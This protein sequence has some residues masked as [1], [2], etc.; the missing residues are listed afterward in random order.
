[1]PAKLDV[2]YGGS[3]PQA[4]F[5]EYHDRYHAAFVDQVRQVTATLGQQLVDY[6]EKIT[7][8][9]T[10]MD[11]GSA[12][13]DA[14]NTPMQIE[15]ASWL[16]NRS[17]SYLIR[18]AGADRHFGTDD[19][20][21][22]YIEDRTGAVLNSPDEK[23]ILDL[24][25]EHARGPMNGLTE[26][27]GVITDQSGAVIPQ[28]TITVRQPL[29]ATTRT[30][31][32]GADGS[33]D[34]A[35]LPAGSYHIEV[36]AP[37][38]VRL[39][40][41][42]RLLP[43]D[44]VM[45]SITLS[46]EAVTQT[47]TVE[48]ADGFVASPPMAAAIGGPVTLPVK[49]SASFA[50]T[51]NLQFEA[52][53]DKA[54]RKDTPASRS[55]DTAH[56]RSY[57]PEA[58]YINPEIITDGDGRASVSIPIADSITTWRMA[59]FASTQSGAIGSGT[60][61]LKVLQD[62]FVDIDLPVTLTQGDNISIP[63]A[64]YDYTGTSG[65]VSLQLKQEDWFSL[66]HDELEK[67]V[68][69][70]AGKVGS[71]Q[72]NI[73]A[74]RI[75]R[76]KLTL[77]AQL[78]GSGERKDVVV[79]EVQVIPNGREQ[80]L[81]FNGRL[82][83]SVQHKVSFPSNA[84]PDATSIFVRLYP[85]PLSQIIEG[86][87]SILSMPGGCFEQTSSNTYPNVLALEYMKRTN[88]L[89]PETH[90]K[91][92]GYIANGYQRLLTF[93]VPGGGF[94]WFGQA[95]ANKILTAYGL[96]EF[97]DMS[98]VSDVDPR[99]IK[100]TAEW[101]IS[102]QQPD[103]SWKPDTYFIN[104]GATNRYNSDPLRI[105]AYVAWALV[106]S[107][108]RGEALEKAKGYIDQH[109]GS[110]QDPYT[111]AIVANFAVDYANDRELTRGAMRALIDAGTEKDDQIWWTTP[112]TGVYSE[113]ESAAVETTGLA[114]QALLKW[115]QASE[116]ARKALNFISAK[117]Q[118]SGNWGTTQATV[119]ALRALVLAT[120]LNASNIRGSLVVSL[121]GKTV[122][123]LNLTA[124]NN[125]PLHQ[126]VLKG[127]DPSAANEVSLKFDGSGSLAYQ[128]VGRS[129]I[130]WDK[131]PDSEALSIDVAYDRTELSRGDIVTATATIH[132]NL[133]KLAKMVM[134]DLGIPPGFD[135]LSEDLQSLQEK[136][137]GDQG[138]RLE[139]FSLTA[140]QAILYFNALSPEQTVKIR[141]RLRAKYPIRARTFASRVYEYY[142][143]AV[144]STA[145]P[146]ELRVVDERVQR[147][148]RD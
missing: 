104:E 62:F 33:F 82:E 69:V 17:Q 50:A 43:R 114:T 88:K 27:T 87:D 1:M 20:L 57:F 90:A 133:P 101:L 146:A 126:F 67:S 2:Q 107:G 9:F 73:D 130:P 7:D 5:A 4:K 49:S 35:G 118:S 136:T 145:K 97:S 81:T 84:I 66:E 134:V 115:G 95:P 105:T 39:S 24:R 23:G 29:L 78:K 34:L 96:M 36:S 123:T 26:I 110:S 40:D 91:A 42:I 148:R 61:S 102:Q 32:S 116:T 144:S 120:Q 22:T 76:F 80:N 138:G 86:M 16:G 13:R 119:M 128:I 31:H 141:F 72:F 83:K 139:K 147:D 12:P 71:S 6:R 140:T 68:H 56:I 14:W 54:L 125:D 93:E 30:A 60:S 111:L 44:R 51:D 142:D 137:Q 58:L 64:I 113:G 38:F 108:Y 10:T 121:D 47:V 70:E 103:G 53:S 129:F 99:L 45:A 124:D 135:L 25:F 52:R 11:G 131:Q 55:A 59:M 94:S 132:N 63:V 15:L 127:I 18:S 46:V 37:G 8:A 98:K 21:V 75:G 106:S 109:S 48:A 85:G 28:A 65:N 41:E 117:K 100:R 122:E 74:K 19:D 3:L 143:P 89:T 92:E 79:R 112:E 77:S